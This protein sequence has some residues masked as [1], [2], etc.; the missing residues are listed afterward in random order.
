MG[1]SIEL[2]VCLFGQSKGR[3]AQI[4]TRGSEAL[5]CMINKKFPCIE[6]FFKAWVT[7]LDQPK[8]TTTLSTVLS[9]LT[10]GFSGTLQL[11]ISKSMETRNQKK[12]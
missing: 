4:H 9:S 12:I 2:F 10:H 3:R 7:T 5:T 11:K 1:L 6:S 8:P